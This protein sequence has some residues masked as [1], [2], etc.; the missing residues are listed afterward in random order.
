MAASVVVEGIGEMDGVAEVNTTIK[1]RFQ[2]NDS[3]IA[4]FMMD[5][6]SVKSLRWMPSRTH[7]CI[8]W[9]K[10]RRT[11][12]YT[13]P[14]HSALLLNTAIHRQIG[15]VIPVLLM[16]VGGRHYDLGDFVIAQ[17]RTPSVS[18]KRR[19]SVVDDTPPGRSASASTTSTP[20]VG[21]SL[22]LSSSSSSIVE[23]YRV[24]LLHHWEVD[25]QFQD[26]ALAIPSVATLYS[27][28]S[29]SCLQWC[30]PD[31]RFGKN[32]VLWGVYEEYPD[33]NVFME[34][35]SHAIQ[36]RFP[37]AIMYGRPCSPDQICHC[38]LF[39]P[40]VGDTIRVHLSGHE[41]VMGE[42]GEMDGVA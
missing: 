22:L 6:G 15:S 33:R 21:S 9:D 2:H 34:A 26:E 18:L 20:P 3:Q 29:D 25:A 19:D 39:R 30:G 37:V 40:A 23:T 10:E 32:C 16:L 35:K 8:T 7:Q 12:H 24:M 36:L 5:G 17:Y 42:L 1:G 38:I 27:V 31:N 11:L 14:T 28:L 41:L 13:L 4:G